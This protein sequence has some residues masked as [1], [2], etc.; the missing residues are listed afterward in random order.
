MASLRAG[1]AAGGDPNKDDHN[2]QAERH[3]ALPFFPGA[4]D[5]VEHVSRLNRVLPDR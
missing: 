3:R 1:P 5:A 2:W 4:I